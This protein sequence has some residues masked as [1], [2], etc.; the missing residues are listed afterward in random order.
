MSEFSI[1]EK[2][3]QKRVYE[4]LNAAQE[5]FTEKGFH[6]ATVN[7]IADRALISKY[8]LYKYFDSKDAIL[9]A[10]LSRG[11]AILTKSVAKRIKNIED[12]RQRLSALINAEF[13][14][15]EKRKSFFQM[16]LTEKL[17]FE[18]EVRNN[19]LS[20]FQE[21]IIFM[22]NEIHD[23]IKKGS[24]RIVNTEDAAYMLFATLRAFA[25]RWLFQGMKGSL[26]DKTDSVYDLVIR[27]L[28]V[29]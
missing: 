15:F 29:K 16:L 2:R 21:H 8:T 13:E 24:F 7:D 23:G 3:E 28:E 25:L 4:I 14:F 19:I 1:K 5:V 6:G 10:I 26:T 12:P 20:S 9:N 11:Y 22:K 17:D 27:C 18:N